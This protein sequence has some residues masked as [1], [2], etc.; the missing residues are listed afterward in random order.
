MASKRESRS[1]AKD[2]K[3]WRTRVTRPTSIGLLMIA[4]AGIIATPSMASAATT[5]AT[6][7][8]AWSDAAGRSVFVR[9]GTYNGFNS[10]GFGLAK[11]MGKHGIRAVSSLQFI[12]HAPNGG[13]KQGDDREYVAY[14]NKL[15][16]NSAGCTVKASIPVRA[17]MSNIYVDTYYGISGIKGAIG[18]KTAYCQNTDAS[19]LCPSWVD[20]AFVGRASKL[21]TSPQGNG[22]TDTTLWSY[23]PMAAG[24]S[25]GQR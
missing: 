14:A 22:I 16:C 23:A 7:T 21:S 1:K 12:T 19:F 6:I 3:S 20:N 2:Q 25:L 11:I 8:S 17:I 5:G 9:V 15:V 18:I 24:T 10:Q 13:T 4:I